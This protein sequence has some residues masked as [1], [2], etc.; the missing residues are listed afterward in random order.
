MKRPLGELYPNYR[1]LPVR[2]KKNFK[3]T[4]TEKEMYDYDNA[5][6]RRTEGEV[7][8][9]FKPAG[10]YPARIYVFMHG[11]MWPARNRRTMGLAFAFPFLKRLMSREEIEHH[12]FNNRLAYHQ[13]ENWDKLLY[14]EQ[15]ECDFLDVQSYWLGTRFMHQL[16]SFRK[17]YKIGA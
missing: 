17:Q 15:F 10:T 12:H 4:A 3:W 7:H 8:Y 13:Y 5:R 1:A 6:P 14:A 11:E 16:K 9:Y 2:L